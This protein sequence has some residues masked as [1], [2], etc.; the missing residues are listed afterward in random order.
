MLKTI[1][2]GLFYKILIVNIK[3]SSPENLTGSQSAIKM[4]LSDNTGLNS[5]L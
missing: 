3:F 1:S 5:E 2:K 4:F